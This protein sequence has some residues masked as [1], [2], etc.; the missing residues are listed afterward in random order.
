MVQNSPHSRRGE[1]GTALQENTTLSVINTHTHTHTHTLSGNIIG[2][3]MHLERK[4][5]C[6]PD[7]KTLS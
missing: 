1:G 2:G 7:V 4:G 5:V 6:A 3:Y